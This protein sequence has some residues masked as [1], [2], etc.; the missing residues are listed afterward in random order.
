MEKKNKID[1]PL[2]RLIKKKR[3]KNQINKIR[4]EKGEVTADN[5]EM[6][7]IIRDYFEQ[8]YVNKIDNLEEMDRFL[9]KFNLP[10]QKQ[11]EVEIMNN[12]ITST[13]IE[14]V[15]KNLPQK[16]KAQDQMASQ[17]NSIKHLEKS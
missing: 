9:E 7:R 13:E 15:I 10:R 6:K 5:A 17:E 16:T 14:A 3:E 11:E 2:A 8:Q 12:P 1:K 4:N